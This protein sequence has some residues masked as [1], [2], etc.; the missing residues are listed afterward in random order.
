MKHI[1]ALLRYAVKTA[2]LLLCFLLETAGVLAAE[3]TD[4]ELRE[5]PGIWAD[6]ATKGD[7]NGLVSLYAR[8]AY[9]HVV[10]TSDELHG[11]QEIYDY[12]EKYEK[13]P[14]KVT[15]TK[16]EETEVFGGVGI[17][18]GQARVEFPGQQPMLTH[19][20][21]VLKKEDG[22]WVIQL[23]HITRIDDK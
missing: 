5:A 13:N 20:S 7:M 10:F 9:V 1:P 4:K 2:T 12:Y 22:R 19:F 11:K 15:I 3:T 23:Q 6:A 18:S 21:T 8:D 14:P 17:L 16:V